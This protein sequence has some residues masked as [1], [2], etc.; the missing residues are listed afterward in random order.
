MTV[1]RYA[2]HA[3]LNRVQKEFSGYEV[4]LGVMRGLRGWH[5]DKYGRLVGMS[6]R[7]IWTPGEN[8]ARCYKEFLDYECDLCSA[9]VTVSYYNFCR[10][11]W[12]RKL[13]NDEH[14]MKECA[15][16]FYA[17][18]DGIMDYEYNGGP[19]AVGVIEG[20]GESVLGTRGFRC[21]KAKIA[22]LVIKKKSDE[23]RIREI[24][25]DV[26]LFSSSR[27]MLKRHPVDEQLHPSTLLRGVTPDN[28]DDFW[29]RP[30]T[31]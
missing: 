20:W 18:H 5:I 6:F 23:P 22:A 14:S 27:K 29:T 31:F 1:D 9:R 11:T 3:G 25:P 26:P 24:Y 21:S 28:A 30:A 17:Y 4:S 8:V 13:R 15:H 2:V 7:V 10:C 12:K 19:D 16:G